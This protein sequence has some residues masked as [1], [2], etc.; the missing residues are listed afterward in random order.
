M[1][2]REV[3]EAVAGGQFHI[4]A[5]STIDE[6]IEILTEKPAGQRQEDGSWPEDSVNGMVDRRLRQMAESLR[7]FSQAKNGEK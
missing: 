3:I 2:K 4:W 1:L 6:G 5:V 7:K